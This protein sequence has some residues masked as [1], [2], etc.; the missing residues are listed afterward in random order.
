MKAI[1]IQ[2]AGQI[3]VVDLPEPEPGPEDVVVEVRYVG[4]CGSDLGMYRGTFPLATYPRILGHEVSGTIVARGAQVPDSILEGD[5]VTLWPYSECGLCPACR[6]GR[7][8]CCQYN[9]T[10]GNCLVQHPRRVIDWRRD[11]PVACAQLGG[12]IASDTGGN[13]GRTAGYHG[14]A[15][16]VVAV[17]RTRQHGLA[18]GRR[19]GPDVSDWLIHCAGV[20]DV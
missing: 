18:R 2:A 14:G 3:E 15:R 11:Y 9:E 13:L 1:S 16:G 4:L 8:N 20:A 19:Y 7:P 6:A 10:L 17:D 12:T 5:R